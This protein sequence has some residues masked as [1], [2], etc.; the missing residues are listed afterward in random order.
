VGFKKFTGF[1]VS[2]SAGNL[3]ANGFF[4]PEEVLRSKTKSWREGAKG[5]VLLRY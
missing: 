4:T 3:P 2:F 1:I 5:F